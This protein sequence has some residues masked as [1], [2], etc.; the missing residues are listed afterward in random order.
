MDVFH[1]TSAQASSGSLISELE[2]EIK[3]RGIPLERKSYAAIVKALE[4]VVIKHYHK[5]IGVCIKH[6]R[7]SHLTLDML[8]ER[9][10]SLHDRTRAREVAHIIWKI[11]ETFSRKLA[12]ANR[13]DHQPPQRCPTLANAPLRTEIHSAKAARLVFRL[14]YRDDRGDRDPRDFACQKARI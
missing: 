8:L 1:T 6:I 4:A 13:I 2:A 12:E 5:L 3:G 9:A 11:T 7:A 14:S 10:E